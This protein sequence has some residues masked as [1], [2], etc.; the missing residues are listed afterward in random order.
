MVEWGAGVAEQLNDSWLSVTIEVRGPRPIDPL[1]TAID[2]D[3]QVEI[4]E[5]EPR[6]VTIKPNGPRWA[7]VPL[8]STLLS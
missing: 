5:A 7:G 3:E 1:G 2:H 8:R 6:V 4:D